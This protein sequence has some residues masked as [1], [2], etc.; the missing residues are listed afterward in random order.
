MAGET[1]LRWARL[2]LVCLIFFIDIASLG[3][4][5]IALPSMKSDLGFD[6]GS[7]QWVL[8]AY[9]L[10]FGGFLMVGGRLG[11]VFEHKFIIQ[12]GMSLFN[13]A[14]LVC[15]VV[16]NKIG[17]VVGRA[18]QGLAA[19]LTIPS[20]QALVSL[21]FEDPKSRVLAF[22]VWGATGSTGFVLGPIF[23]GLFSSLA[24]WRWIFWFTLIVE[25]TLQALSLLLLWAFKGPG[26]NSQDNDKS[27]FNIL[28]RF[29]PLGICLSIPGLILLVYGLTT[30]NIH[31]WDQASVIA[32]IVI[33]VCLLGAFAFVELRFAAH[34][35]IPIYLWS[36]TIKISGCVIAAFTYA[37]W[38]GAN[39]LL[40]LQLQDFGFSALQTSVHFLP[41]GITACVV[42]F[43]I[44]HLLSPVGPRL[45]LT[46]SWILAIVGV[47][48]LSLMN[49]NDDYWR[50]C[51]PGMILYIT[52][53]GTVYYV[54]NVVVVASAL[55]KDQGSISGVYNMCLN[56]GGAVLGVA[57]LTVIDNSVTANNGGQKDAQARLDGYRA[58]YYGAIFMCGLAIILSVLA[59][60]PKK[61]ADATADEQCEAESDSSRATPSS[62]ENV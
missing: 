18:F 61:G 34:P 56:V 53:V 20:A 5:T 58:G 51:L 52:G 50:Y 24:N 11:D 38:Q 54:G 44:P 29:D 16:P 27:T 6:Q 7:L 48:L 49:S 9:A 47:F 26:T 15:G 36:D 60:R 32:T 35:L 41:L 39:Y 1:A 10:T 40:T 2:A 19:A 37:V 12:V 23:G 14:T 13:I 33:A 46:I 43:I 17:L 25:G 8:T 45:L 55:A 21:L 59:I 30:G 31:G 3:M 62:K 22:G 57:V 42:N 4:C 28:S